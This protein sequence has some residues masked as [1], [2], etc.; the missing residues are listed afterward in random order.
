LLIDDIAGSALYYPMRNWARWAATANN[1]GIG[2]PRS[3][4]TCREY[5]EPAGD[6]W[7]TPISGIDEDEAE[8]VDAI[9]MRLPADLIVVVRTHY[10]DNGTT[11]QKIRKLDM[12]KSTY[13]ER[14][15]SAR[16][17][18]YVAFVINSSKPQIDVDIPELL[19]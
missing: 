16:R 3:S 4:P 10:I 17:M 8:R 5:R 12:M 18:I 13:Y 9:I 11:P 7:D 19:V 1:P 15:W 2:Y 6:T 14:L